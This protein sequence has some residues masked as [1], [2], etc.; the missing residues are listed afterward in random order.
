MLPTLVMVCG[1]L[2][3]RAMMT[4]LATIQTVVMNV[5]YFCSGIRVPGCHINNDSVGNEAYNGD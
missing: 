3:A 4:V 2:V 5:A 1:S